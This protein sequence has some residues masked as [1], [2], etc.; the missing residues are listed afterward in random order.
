MRTSKKLALIGLLSLCACGS[1][2]NGSAPVAGPGGDNGLDGGPSSNGGTCVAKGGADEPDDKGIDQ[3]C[4]GA[5]GVVGVDVYVSGSGTDTNA[6]TPGQPL[7]TIAAALKLANGRGGKVLVSSGS[8]A[9]DAI[10]APGTWS[11]FG[12]YAS[13]FTGAPKRSSTVLVG[14]ATGVLIDGGASARLAHLTVRGAASTDPQHPSSVAIVSSADDLT[15]DDVDL[16][17]ADGRDGAPGAVG[18]PGN[19]G[20]PG[21]DADT[22]TRLMCRGSV[23]PSFSFGATKYM[24]NVEGKHPGNF[25]TSTAAETGSDGAPGTDGVDASGTP[26]LTDGALVFGQGEP[27]ASN[28]RPGF[29]GPGGGG[30]SP[31]GQQWYVGGAGGSGGCPGFGGE[32]GHSG[33]ASVGLLVLRGSVHVTRSLV[34]TGLGGAGGDGGAGGPGGAGGRP[35]LP[36]ANPSLGSPFPGACT[37][38]NDPAHAACAE[39]GGT[40]GAGGLGGHGGG[41]AGGWSVG[42]MLAAGATAQVDDVTTV[43]LGRPGTGGTGNGGGRAPGGKSARTY[44]IP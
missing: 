8:F 26:K 28:G 17:A 21:G 30:G 11:L 27:G 32:G 16:E 24:Q 6:G 10:K 19:P 34:H 35:G 42:V 41:G 1:A 14:G 4:D 40:G 25:S 20:A 22:P 33:G 15:L 3:N 37:T 38:A 31:D 7:R 43:D 44:T 36:T 18:L 12:G 29:G 13:S 9:L 2:D 23:Q 39:Y 5:D